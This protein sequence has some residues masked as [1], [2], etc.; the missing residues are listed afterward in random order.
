MYHE[1][2]WFTWFIGDLFG[3]L[4]SLNGRNPSEKLSK[5]GSKTIF[6][7]SK[8]IIIHPCLFLYI[9]GGAILSLYLLFI[10]PN[11]I[12]QKSEFD[13]ISNGSWG[14]F[15]YPLEDLGW[16]PW[17]YPIIKD[18][19]RRSSI[20][21]LGKKMVLKKMT[22][23]CSFLGTKK[24]INKPQYSEFCTE[25]ETFCHIRC[26]FC[27]N[28]GDDSNWMCLLRL[29]GHLNPAYCILW[30]A[31]LRAWLS[32]TTAIMKDPILPGILAMQIIIDFIWF[33]SSE[34]HFVSFFPHFLGRDLL[35][36]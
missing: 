18:H 6:K 4:R 21:W 1:G 2:R 5:L 35:F 13:H 8:L 10:T 24:D 17:G 7:K 28:P 23:F 14:R 36:A 20:F 16:H 26:I 3:Q 25:I 34:V 22:I 31:W 27:W 12:A 32:P 33:P 11:I 29:F 30:G 15:Q 9:L 19:L